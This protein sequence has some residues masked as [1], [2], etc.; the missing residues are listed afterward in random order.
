MIVNRDDRFKRILLGGASGDILGAVAENK[1][2][3]RIMERF[4]ELR[5]FQKKFASF[6]CYTDDTQMTIALAS[7]IIEM[8][9]AN[10]EHCAKKIRG[11]F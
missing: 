1:S 9:G 11:V 2:R 7:S 5:D 8:S 6:G 3:A 10:A 4:G